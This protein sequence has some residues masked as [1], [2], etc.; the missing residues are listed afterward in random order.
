MIETWKTASNPAA[1][2]EEI[3]K[4]EVDATVSTHTGLEPVGLM[5]GA[6]S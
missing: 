2:D 5:E 4:K 3:D 6:G 1:E